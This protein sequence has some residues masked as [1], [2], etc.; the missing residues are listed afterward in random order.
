ML[1]EEKEYTVREMP[2]ARGFFV[3]RVKALMA[4]FVF[5]ALVIIIIVLAVMLAQEKGK[6]KPIGKVKKDNKATGKLSLG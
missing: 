3:S 1:K 2:G 4:V 5:V 6:D